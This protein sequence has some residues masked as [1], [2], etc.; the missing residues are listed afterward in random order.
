MWVVITEALELL[1]RLLLLR[2]A[3]YWEGDMRSMNGVSWEGLPDGCFVEI[4]KW[5]DGLS[6]LQAQITCS[7]LLQLGRVVDVWVH[8][9]RRDAGYFVPEKYRKYLSLMKLYR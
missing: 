1:H 5:C 8:V 6:I 3:E 2:I 7:R 4:L 9:L